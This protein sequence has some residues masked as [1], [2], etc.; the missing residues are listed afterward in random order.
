[1]IEECPVNLEC[2]L[3]RTIPFSIDE[4]F[5]GE[6]VQGYSSKKYLT[7]GLPD[8]KKVDPIVFSM[9]DYNYWAVG[10]HLGRAWSSGEKFKPKTK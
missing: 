4:A 2:R 9:H 8:V 1:M 6:I 10:R 3:I 5:I 7:K